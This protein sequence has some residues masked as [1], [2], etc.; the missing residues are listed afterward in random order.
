MHRRNNL[1]KSTKRRRLLDEKNYIKT[2]SHNN[3]FIT[4][5]SVELNNTCT[6]VT[7]EPF[8]EPTTNYTDVDNHVTYHSPSVGFDL[9]TMM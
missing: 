4:L 1:S 6:I 9:T 7:N 8:I 5:R 2:L 3:S